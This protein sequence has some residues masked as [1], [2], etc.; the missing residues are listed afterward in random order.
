VLLLGKGP[1]EARLREDIATHGWQERVRLLGF[2]DDLPRL[3]PCLDV[4][5]H[6]AEMEGLGVSLLQAAACGVPIVASAVGGIPE[7]VRDNGCL[8]P[9]GDSAALA[10]ALTRVLDDPQAAARMGER[11]RWW[12]EQQFSVPAMVA[13][14]LAAYRRVLDGTATQP[15]PELAAAD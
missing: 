3:L 1:L 11:G 2:R 6:P 7:V 8:V 5:A 9:A 14:N 15:Q 4:L 10:Q 13:G 12:V